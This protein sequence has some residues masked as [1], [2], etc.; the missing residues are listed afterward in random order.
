MTINKNEMRAAQYNNY[1]SPDVF[2]EGYIAIPLVK[3]GEVLIRVHGTSVNSMDTMF[4]AGKLKILT[5]QKFPKGTGADFAGE[6]AELGV[7]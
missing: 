3:P 7:M 2:Y 1:G 4:R 6:V 5:G